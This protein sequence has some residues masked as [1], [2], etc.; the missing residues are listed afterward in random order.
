MTRVTEAVAHRQRWLY[1]VHDW[2][3]TRVKEDLQTRIHID[4]HS[5]GYFELPGAL[6]RT[7]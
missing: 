7:L 2:V 6:C 4:T 3:V 5:L 1:R